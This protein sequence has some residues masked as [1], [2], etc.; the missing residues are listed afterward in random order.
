MY[1]AC[2]NPRQ[3]LPPV[4]ELANLTRVSIRPDSSVIS[5]CILWWA[6]DL[7]RT[8]TGDVTAV[9]VDLWDP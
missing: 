2:A 5:T 8:A 7:Y 6:V 3:D 9:T 1:P 4:P